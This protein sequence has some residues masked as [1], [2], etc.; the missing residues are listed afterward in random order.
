MTRKTLVWVDVGMA[1]AVGTF[2]ALVLFARNSA[3]FEVLMMTFMVAM[4][5]WAFVAEVAAIRAEAPKTTT[6]REPAA[7]APR[8]PVAH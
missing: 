1:I 4:V 3:A 5:A 2:I 7:Q 8:K 6:G